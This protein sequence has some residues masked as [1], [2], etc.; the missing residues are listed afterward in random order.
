MYDTFYVVTARLC[1]KYRP[2][3]W[4]ACPT[5]PGPGYPYSLHMK[6]SSCM[7]RP[8]WLPFATGL[9]FLI[10]G[11]SVIRALGHNMKQGT[12]LLHARHSEKLPGEQPRQQSL[13]LPESDKLKSRSC[14]KA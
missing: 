2:G 9:L 6:L 8:L 3:G 7:V 10:A 14:E 13:T 5:I 1:H 12:Y 11:N 4:G